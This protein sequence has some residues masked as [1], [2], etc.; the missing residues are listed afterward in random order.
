MI[1]ATKNNKRIRASPKEK[2]TCPLCNQEVIAKCGEIKIW[3][4][5]HK[6]KTDCE[7]EPETK[8]HLNMKFFL[9]D[10][11]PH[12]IIEYNLGFAIADLYDKIDNVAIEVQH[13]PISKDKFLERT[14]NY[15][16]NGIS[17]L[18][19]FDNC[20]LKENCP[21]FLREAHK[22][23]FGRIYVYKKEKIYPVHF[24]RIEREIKINT[25]FSDIIPEYYDEFGD[26][27]ITSFYKL[28]REYLFYKEVNYYLFIKTYNKLMDINISKF[29]DNKFW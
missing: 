18:W 3:H 17:V 26:G 13:S 16:N 6:N 11:L 22:L 19:I 21:E 20:L 15:S 7:F 29:N 4:W 14:K 9:K 8:E 1:W 25:D 5:A 27:Y 23:Y 10:K 2:A 24:E 28:K 12:L